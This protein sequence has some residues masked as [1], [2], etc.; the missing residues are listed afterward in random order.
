VLPS[1]SAKSP[2]SRNIGCTAETKGLVLGRE[3]PSA[4]LF[5]SPLQFDIEAYNNATTNTITVTHVSATDHKVNTDSI[6]TTG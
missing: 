3:N 5:N 2:V 4:P 6:C 1:V